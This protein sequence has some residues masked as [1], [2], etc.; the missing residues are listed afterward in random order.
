MCQV[1]KKKKQPAVSKTRGRHLQRSCRHAGFHFHLR[2][3]RVSAI[4][5]TSFRV[6]CASFRS[7]LFHNGCCLGNG[8]IAKLC[9]VAGMLADR[10][11]FHLPR[12]ISFRTICG[13]PVSV[14]SIRV[15]QVASLWPAR[16]DL[17]DVLSVPS[18]NKVEKYPVMDVQWRTIPLIERKAHAR[19][20][21]YTF[22][23]HM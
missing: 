18:V 1:S 21:T 9:H 17:L 16:T 22:N 3:Q 8:R 10:R 23:R 13:Q 12:A 15:P 20:R 4:K 19:T 6:V 14:C 2:N 7:S 5:P 11:F